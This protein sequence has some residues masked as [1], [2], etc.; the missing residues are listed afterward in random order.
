LIIRN[1]WGEAGPDYP[2]PPRGN[3][4]LEV[5]L[6][7]SP[8]IIKIKILEAKTLFDGDNDDDDDDDDSNNI[9]LHNSVITG[10]TGYS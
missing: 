9:V 5:T 3:P 10:N 8:P 4:V 6:K 7:K 1:I 2:G